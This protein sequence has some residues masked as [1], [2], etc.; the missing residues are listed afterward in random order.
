MG[1]G[2]L[3]TPPGSA[4]ASIAEPPARPPR[5]RDGRFLTVLRFHNETESAAPSQGY[6]YRASDGMRIIA[7]LD[8]TPHGRLLHVSL[9]Y[10]DR[11]P[12]WEDIR[13]VRD[14]FYPEDVDVM[15]VLPRAADYVNV[16]EHC[17]H[18][19]QT[20]TVWGIG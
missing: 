4:P 18:L 14:A 11:D 16:H 13:A 20:P 8:G 17:F 19:W 12:S 6:G 9:S 7:S 3:W 1:D 15:M 10:A 2:A 5:L